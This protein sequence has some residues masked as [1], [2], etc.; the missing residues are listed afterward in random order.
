MAVRLKLLV[1]LFSCAPYLP[2]AHGAERSG[3]AAYLNEFERYANAAAAL[4]TEFQSSIDAASGE[5]R[6]YLYWTYNH[7][8][9][10]WVQ[11]ENLRRQ[12]ELAV[13]AQSYLEEESSRTILRDQ[14][15][16][17]R[18]QLGDAVNNLQQNIP[19][20]RRLNQLWLNE[21]LCSLLSE[22]RATVDRLRADQCARMPCA[23]DR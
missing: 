19:E 5:D 8:I 22:V 15:E 17:V 10:S 18:W 1:L 14:A 16:F 20:V 6:F 23:V 11:V 7:L 2:V 3:D 21:A 13:E 12:L 9:D 4:Q